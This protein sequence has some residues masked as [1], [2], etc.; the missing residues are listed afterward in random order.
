[1][2]GW[3]DGGEEE[4]KGNPEASTG[5]WLKG[6]GGGGDMD[7]T[8]T[9]FSVVNGEPRAGTRKTRL[10]RGEMGKRC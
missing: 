1:M 6:D 10:T 3:M 8:H 7:I 9:N 4:D 2:D 5:T